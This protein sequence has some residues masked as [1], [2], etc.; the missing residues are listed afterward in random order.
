MSYPKDVVA[1]AWDEAAGECER[2]GT[3]LIHPNRGKPG[4]Q[5][6]WIPYYMARGDPRGRRTAANYESLCLRCYG[7]IRT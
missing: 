1:V 3:P 2:C 5:G 7:N 6:A 4:A